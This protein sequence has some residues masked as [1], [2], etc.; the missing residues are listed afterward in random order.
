MGICD[1]K[2]KPTDNSYLTNQRIPGFFDIS[3]QGDKLDASTNIEGSSTVGQVV[4][5]NKIS[6]EIIPYL[7]YDDLEGV[8]GDIP[9]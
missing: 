4:Y 1:N 7:K 6:P 3:G 9:K 2:S 8:T 5:Q